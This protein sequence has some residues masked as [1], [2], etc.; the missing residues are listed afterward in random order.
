M[1]KQRTVSRLKTTTVGTV[2]FLAGIINGLLG[3]AGGILLVY[4]LPYFLK[5]DAPLPVPFCHDLTPPMEGRDRMATALA[6]MLPVTAVSF[7]SY[8]LSGMAPALSTLTWLFLPATLGGLCGAWL[9]GRIQA[10]FLR[11]MFAV[12]VIVSGIRMIF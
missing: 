2:G 10:D 5:A 11:R 6:V 4:T 12:L 1:T 3:A 7:I 9:L 8:A